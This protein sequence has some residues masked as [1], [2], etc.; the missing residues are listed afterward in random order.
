MYIFIHLLV[1]FAILATNP[2]N[3]LISNT[4]NTFLS[5]IQTYDLDSL[6][7]GYK[8]IAPT[9]ALQYDIL[10]PEIPSKY[11]TISEDN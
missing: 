7:R 9:Q 1:Y 5:F 8:T 3:P 2:K 11:L 4:T 10:Q 6:R